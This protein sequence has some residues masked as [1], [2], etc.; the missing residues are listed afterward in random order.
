MHSQGSSVCLA[1]VLL[2]LQRFVLRTL[3]RFLSLLDTDSFNR[4]ARAWLD[5]GESEL[6]SNKA[7]WLDADVC[8]RIAWLDTGGTGISSDR[9]AWLDTDVSDTAGWLDTGGTEFSDMAAWLDT[10][11]SDWLECESG[12]MMSCPVDSSNTTA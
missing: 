2:F 5:T 3:W 9:A 7:A 8:D 1:L 4:T 11:D 12:N 10:G 6:S